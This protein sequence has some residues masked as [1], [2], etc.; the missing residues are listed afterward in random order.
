MR[1]ARWALF[2]CVVELQWNKALERLGLKLS[3]ADSE[4][5]FASFDVNAKGLIN[6]AQ[7]SLVICGRGVV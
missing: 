4:R 7:L 6:Y 5:L 2:N 1:P 3:A